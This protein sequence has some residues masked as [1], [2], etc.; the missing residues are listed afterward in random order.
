M[1]DVRQRATARQAYALEDLAVGM[2]ACYFHT[3]TDADIGQFGDLSGDHIPLHLVEEFGKN[4]R[5]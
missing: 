5:F 4:T 2:S 3:V 1:D